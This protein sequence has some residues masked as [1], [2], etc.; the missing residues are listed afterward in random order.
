MLVSCG[1]RKC[2]GAG[3]HA[4][5]WANQRPVSRSRDDAQPMRGQCGAQAEGDK[6]IHAD[7]TLSAQ[8]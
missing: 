2:R 1:V 4:P 6:M 8:L 7:T 5:A 3:T